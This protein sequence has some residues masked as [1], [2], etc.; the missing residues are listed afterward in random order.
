MMD[1]VGARNTGRLAIGVG[2]G[3]AGSAACLLTYFAAGGPFGTINDI[4]NAATGVLS[5]FLAWQLRG[6]IPGRLGHAAAG[7]AFIGAATTVVGSTLVVTGTT[8]FFLAG[9]VSSVGF[10]GIGAWLVVVNRRPGKAG[11]WPRRLRAAGLAAGLLMA[12]GAVSAPGILLRLDDMATA[13]AWVYI[14]SLGWLGTYIVYPAWALWLGLVETRLVG[15]SPRRA[16]IASP[17]PSEVST[18][19][20]R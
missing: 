15:R 12:L 17:E 4:G 13:P 9:H 6:Q 11:A 8:G 14:G 3:A 10:A 7:A 5:A 16:V 19:T 1:E 18:W 20:G 2:V